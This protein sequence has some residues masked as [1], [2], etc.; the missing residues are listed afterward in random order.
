MQVVD[1]YEPWIG[2]LGLNNDIY[3]VFPAK[4][5]FYAQDNINFSGMILNFGLRA[6]YWFPGKFVTDAVNNPAVPIPAQIRQ[7]Y[8][9]DTY[10]FFGNR[11]KARIS[12]RLGISH[13]VSDYQTLFFSYGHFSKWPY[14]TGCLC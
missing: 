5:D 6:D 9:T 8:F 3:K 12:P 14:S 1:I 11:F 13:P 10:N 7:A 4:G 2:Q